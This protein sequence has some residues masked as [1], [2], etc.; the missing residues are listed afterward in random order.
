MDFFSKFFNH[1][2]EADSKGPPKT[3]TSLRK[4]TKMS[5]ATDRKSRDAARKRAERASQPKKAQMSAA[6]LIKQVI[7]VKT[8]D[9]G[10]E[11]IYKDSYNSNFHTPINPDKEL[12][13][14]DAKNLTKDETFIQTLASQQLFGDLKKKA[15]AQER[16]RATT[17]LKAAEGTSEEDADTGPEVEKR[18]FVKPKKMSMQDLVASMSGMDSAQ[19]GAIPFDLRQEYFLK[20][21]DPM[22]AKDF[23]QLSFESVAAKF[24]ISKVD[25]PYNEQVRNALIMLSRLKA[26]ASDQ[27]LSFVTNIKNG[28]Y[29]QFNREAFEQAKK[30]LSQVGDECLQLMVSAS[31]AG[32][33]GVASE[34]QMDFKCGNIKFAVN[35]QGEISLSNSDMSQNGKSIKKTIQKS[36][37]QIMQDPT[38]ADK[39]PVYKETVT[40][41]ND[42]MANSGG[43]M[44]TDATFE[45]L[46]KDPNI[47]AFM[48][49][50]VITSPTGVV[51]GPM[52]LP[53]GQL[54]PAI[55][56]KKFESDM[57]RIVDR[58]IAQE[59]G[60]K[61]P[62][63]RSLIQASVTNQLRGDGSVDPE[64]APSHLVTG[65][66][67]F[68]LSDDYFSA[69]SSTSD[70]K[71]EKNNKAVTQKPNDINKYKVVIEQTEQLPPDQIQ[72]PVDPM[73]QIR[74]LIA[75]SMTP[76][77][78]SPIE[79]LTNT[80]TK[81]YNFDMNISLLP[82]IA[83]KDIH[84][85]EYNYLTV[86]GKKFKIPVS[87]DQELVAASMEEQYVVANSLLLEGFENNN[88]LR[89]LYYTNALSYDNIEQIVGARHIG[90]AESR[91]Y[92]IPILETLTVNLTVHPNLLNECLIYIEE[93]KK[94]HRDYKREY[95][96][97]HGKP[98]Q[99]KK[100][101]KRVTA[102]RRMEREGRVHK[103]DGKDVDHKT[104]LRNGGSNGKTNL[105]IRSRSENRSDNGKYK[106]QP[107]DK[108]RN[109]E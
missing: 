100:R 76:L 14:E 32:L 15:E 78:S 67:I 5:S 1:L 16:K 56:F 44:M 81:N 43:A 38:L 71:I 105:R 42:I 3:A 50:E 58:F 75:S 20:N 80:L 57:E 11:L 22:A 60:K 27:E 101:A 31:E 108:P 65:N 36:L 96:L 88:V 6:Q 72:Q 12:S 66:G 74:D 62:F 26:G 18:K 91:N 40:Q 54:N 2:T 9:G 49:Q 25:L 69:I 64:N 46:S 23:D 95:K 99:I 68:P 51:L 61:A 41:I 17:E 97:F 28:M 63:M 106:G 82:G 70:I 8:A 85:V 98:S 24:G 35:A 94:R 109:D 107:A 13:I 7:A 103:G 102:R 37:M 30:I 4:E 19:L 83:P 90:L 21:R 89:A 59:K 55:S 86:H 73:Q 39:D 34:G 77:G 92:L 84:G 10:T 33:A 29:T 48:Q 45:K 47:F 104:P 93:A 87:R 52:A 79:A 53:N